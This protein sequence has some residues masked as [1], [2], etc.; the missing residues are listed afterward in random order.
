MGAVDGKV[1][2]RSGKKEREGASDISILVFK[3]CLR[4]KK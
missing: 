4:N 3:T 2:G 1:P